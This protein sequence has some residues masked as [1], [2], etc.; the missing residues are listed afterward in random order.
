MLSDV[1]AHVST[2]SV[3]EQ[4]TVTIAGVESL[5]DVH[6]DAPATAAA[7]RSLLPLTGQLIHPRWSRE[8]IWLPM[9]EGHLNL[10]PENATRHPLP[11]ELIVDPGEASGA[12]MLLASGSC[13]FGSKAGPLHRNHVLTLQYVGD[14]LR[15]LGQRAMWKG[16]LD[17]QF[18]TCSPPGTPSAT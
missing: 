5:A 18:D 3:R 14:A 11:G 10:S 15:E 2:E 8:A 6:P 16:A 7:I 12:E 17:V 4:L 9:G 1:K 13:A